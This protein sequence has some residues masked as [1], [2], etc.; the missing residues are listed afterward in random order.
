MASQMKEILEQLQQVNGDFGKAIENKGK[1]TKIVGGKKVTDTIENVKEKEI[2]E[3]KNLADYLIDTDLKTNGSIKSEADL[4]NVKAEIDKLLATLEKMGKSKTLG[5]GSH[6]TAKQQVEEVLNK[7]KAYQKELTD[8]DKAIQTY[9]TKGYDVEEHKR[10]EERKK[11]DKEREIERLNKI[12]D[13]E[14]DYEEIFEK[15]FEEYTKS[16][17]QYRTAT[18]LKNLSEE[19]AKVKNELKNEKDQTKVAELLKNKQE[20]LKQFNDTRKD[21]IDKFGDTDIPDTEEKIEKE[22]K[23]K[24]D[25]LINDSVYKGIAVKKAFEAKMG[26]IVDTS[27][28]PHQIKNQFLAGKIQAF[29]AAYGIE[30]STILGNMNIKQVAETTM[31]ARNDLE[32]QRL[33]T[34]NEIKEIENTINKLGELDKAKQNYDV[35]GQ[36]TDAELLETPTAK[37][38]VKNKV[39]TEF[40]NANLPA[41]IDDYKTADRKYLRKALKETVYKGKRGAGLRAW[42]AS[43]NRKYGL[44]KVQEEYRKNASKEYIDEIRKAVEDKYNAAKND[45]DAFKARYEQKGIEQ[46][47][48]GNGSK[49]QVYDE[50]DREG[51]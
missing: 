51:R 1:R 9:K 47:I 29:C 41:E 3:A 25:A 35:I 42:F 23:K 19:L 30:E 49:T 21:Y 31:N 12:I 22:G 24:A 11:G 50:L 38:N 7:V 6:D 2:E 14:K 44:K 16:E 45:R 43:R 48:S 15:E 28:T 39:E 26:S 18:E 8:K 34:V 20:I 32:N 5:D 37:K 27:V 33:V 13:I 40:S 46:V 17:E 4:K 36:K 10:Y